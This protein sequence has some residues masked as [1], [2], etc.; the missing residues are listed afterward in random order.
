MDQAQTFYSQAIDRTNNT[1]EREHL[2]GRLSSIAD[3]N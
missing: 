3:S 2:M 1:A